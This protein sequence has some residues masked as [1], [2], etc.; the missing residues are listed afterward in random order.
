MFNLYTIHTPTTPPKILS[1]FGCSLALGL[2]FNYLFYG[3]VPGISFPI[4]VGIILIGLFLLSSYFKTRLNSSVF[5]LTIP[6]LFFALMVAVRASG[7]LT[8]LN[9]AT[10]L[11]LLLLI[12]NIVTGQKLQEYI[13]KNYLKTIFTPLQ[14][15]Q[16]A[17]RTLSDLLTLHHTLKEHKKFSL[18]LK[19]ILMAVPFLFVFLVLFSSADLAFY[20]YV[21]KII[22][23]TPETIYRTILIVFVTIGF[24]G[25]YRF[26][27]GTSSAPTPDA[28]DNNQSYKMGNIE[29]SV[30][31]GLINLLFLTFIIVQL[32]YL[33]GGE[34]N[35]TALGFTYAEYARKG[36]FEL[37]LVAVLSFLI[38]WTTE[39]YAVKN[40]YRHSLSFMWL[41]SALTAQ[42]LVVIVSA[43]K[44]LF[45]YEQAFGFTTMRFYSH[46]FI[47]W[48]SVIFVFLLYK[49]IANR[50][51]NKFALAAFISALGFLAAVNLLNPD[52]F[53]ARQNL[54][55]FTATKNLDV[56]YLAWLSVDALPVTE[57]ILDLPDDNLKRT[58]AQALY[59]KK[60][61][62]ETPIFK[63]WQSSNIARKK[64]EQI[65][66]TREKFL[67]ENKEYSSPSQSFP[68]PR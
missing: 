57:P 16:S 58:F 33:F 13:I 31:L 55:H 40:N 11:Y 4:Y 29:I 47:I 66:K 21:S 39:K 12:A 68:T 54:N 43:F 62:L 32:K 52:A 65:L 42:V 36:F 48:L 2:F 6:L 56:Y 9:I 22:R 30:F 23:I 17:I 27:L 45:L 38:L 63:N 49:I 1:I 20:K 34:R 51:E 14:F 10:S 8:F 37:L 61:S 25:A 60:Q 28:S 5:I 15:I 44:R 41:G 7:F 26:A 53:I 18:V 3:R 19:G 67:E 59:W 24:M 35:I 50:Q 46:T 64:A